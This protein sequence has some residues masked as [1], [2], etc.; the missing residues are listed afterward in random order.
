MN[1]KGIICCEE[2]QAVTKEFRRLGIEVYSNDLKDCSGGHPEW[3]IKGDAFD[4]IKQVDPL[5]MIAHPPCTH[6]A[7]SGSKHFKQKLRD[8]RQQEGIALFMKF[9]R[10]GIKHTCL[11][12]PISIMSEIYKKPTQ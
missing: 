2:S 7:V 6:I 9:T 11:E 3:H 8:G 1:I 4:A 10:T 5:F 12:N